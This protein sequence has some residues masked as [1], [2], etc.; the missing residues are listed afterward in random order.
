MDFFT[1]LVRFETTLWN[2]VERGLG[3][4]RRVSMANLLA[5]RVLDGHGG[6]GRVN[7]LS[8][9]LDITIGAASKLVDRLERAGLAQRRPH[10]D[11]RRSSLISLT[12]DGQQALAD[13]LVT[14]ERLLADLLADTGDVAAAAESIRR[15]QAALESPRTEG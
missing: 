12:P 9:E 7:E 3:E 10:P 1:L 15:L 5:L 13:G 8:D 11:D 2:R 6:N 14:A 4:D